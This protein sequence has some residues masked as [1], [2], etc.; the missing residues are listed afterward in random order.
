LKPG[1]LQADFSTNS[2]SRMTFAS[3]LEPWV[4]RAD[5]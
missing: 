3:S 4:P 1:F 2:S 5:R